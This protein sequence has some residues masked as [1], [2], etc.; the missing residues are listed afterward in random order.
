MSDSVSRQT[1][2]ALMPPGNLWNPEID[3]GLDQLL[4]GIVESTEDI[5]SFLA[6]LGNLRNPTLTTILSDLEKEYGIDIDTN[7][8]EAVRRMR[9]ATKAFKNKSNGSVDVLQSALDSSGF[10]TLTVYENSP[11]VDPAI[12]LTEAFTMVA[13]GDN[14]YAGF[15]PSAG[16]PSTAIAGRIGGELLVNGDIFSQVP[17]YLSQAGGSYA[18]GLYGNAGIFDEFKRIPITYDVPTDPNDWPL[19][20][21]NLSIHGAV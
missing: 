6:E 19:V 3:K 7:L 10:D 9:L 20:F 12:F 5:A 8:T 4:E 2:N 21:S 13:G 1:L 14:A 18:G 16:P 17:A 15:I 11:A